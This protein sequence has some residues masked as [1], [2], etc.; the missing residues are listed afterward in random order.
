MKK[1]IAVIGML[2]I[3]VACAKSE[4]TATTKAN[5]AVATPAQ[6]AAA[7]DAT[8]SGAPASNLLTG[9]V[10]ETLDA[11]G[12]TYLRIATSGGEQWAAVPA[13]KVKKGDTVSVAAQMTMEKFESKTLNRTFDTIVFGSIAGDSASAAAS[14]VQA[15]MPAGHPPLNETAGTKMPA[16]I[17]PMMASALADSASQHM[18]SP[19]AGG[20]KVERAPGGKTVAEA[21]AEKES[22]NGK[23]VIVR[24]KVVKFLGGI[25]GRNWMHV[26]DGTGSAEKGDNDLTVTTNEKVNVGDVVTVKGKL[27]AG[28][29]FGA[30]YRYEVILEGAKVQ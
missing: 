3:A 29:D 12:Y 2:V 5:P 15:Q 11:G 23:E 24:G 22:L 20:I 21:W 13:A 8:A 10:A 7:P 1:T 17:P 14:P 6:T 19:P 4:Q 9:K 28:K 30:G 27:A 16:K 18:Q 26:Q 25:M